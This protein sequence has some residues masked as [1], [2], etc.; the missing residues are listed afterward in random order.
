MSEAVEALQTPWEESPEGPPHVK[1]VNLVELVSL[2]YIFVAKLLAL[3]AMELTTEDRKYH[4]GQEDSGLPSE[5]N[6]KPNWDWTLWW[7]LTL[8]EVTEQP[9]QTNQQQAKRVYVVRAIRL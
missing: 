4:G 6:W 1:T 7:T 3:L 8:G 2:Q 5:L 9:E